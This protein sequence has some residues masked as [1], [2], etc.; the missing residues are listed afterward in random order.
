MMGS[1]KLVWLAATIA[2]PDRGTYSAPLTRRRKMTLAMTRQKRRLPRWIAT[3]IAFSTEKPSK[4]AD[5]IL[6][7]CLSQM[8]GKNMV[9]SRG[10][11]GWTDPAIDV[12]LHR[13]NNL[14]RIE[15]GGIDGHGVLRLPQR[16]GASPQVSGVP[17]LDVLGE[18]H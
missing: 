17:H 1:R 10:P 7:G 14:K 3:C 8:Q 18:F 4:N 5:F 2:A 15:I 9:P 6:H 12:V 16:R 11:L 13:S